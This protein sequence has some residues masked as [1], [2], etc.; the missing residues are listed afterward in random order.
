MVYNQMNAQ[1]VAGEEN[2]RDATLV[3]MG[4]NVKRVGSGCA[5][6][7]ELQNK[8]LHNFHHIFLRAYYTALLKA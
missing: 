6:L 4:V 2:R 7:V 3:Q 1:A 5:E 8:T